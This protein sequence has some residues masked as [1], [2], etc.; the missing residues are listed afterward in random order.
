M[1]MQFTCPGTNKVVK[2]RED[3]DGNNIAPFWSK[4]ISTKCPFCTEIHSFPFSLAYVEMALD[5]Q[6]VALPKDA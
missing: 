5:T 4:T 1:F 6:G 3:F 2:F